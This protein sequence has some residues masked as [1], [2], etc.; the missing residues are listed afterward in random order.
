[1]DNNR[2]GTKY[3]HVFADLIK[4]ARGEHTVDSDSLYKEANKQILPILDKM[5]EE[6]FLPGSSFQGKENV[7]EFVEMVNSG[8]HGL[9]LC[10]HY[11]NFDL[12]AL[13]YMLRMD[14]GPA[15]PEL[16]EKIVAIAGKKLTEEN[17]FVSAYAEAYNR[18]IIYP[19]RS[20]AAIK[21]PVKRAEE[22]AISRKINMGSMRCLDACRR[23][24]QV[25]MVFP[26]GTR[27]RPGVPDT[28]R[29]VRE[30]DSYLR[31]TD[32]F[33]PV[34]INGNCLR[35]SED[36]PNDMLMDVV[37]EDKVT[38]A[39]GK[40]V[41][42]KTFREGILSKLGEDYDGDKKQ[43]VVDGIMEILEEQHNKYAD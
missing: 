6:N 15:G 18:I 5:L 19:S 33:L 31:M 39:A 40:P 13:S 38:F 21:D 37:C 16:A 12:P 23:R 28:K 41:D 42:C 20:I 17:P 34:S 29:G 30:I 26:A 27:Y 32:V 4:Y 2:L 1:M 8:K 35:I 10:E 25:I 7:A 9:I 24:G 36:Y 14:G 3:K 43:V 22:E 11:S